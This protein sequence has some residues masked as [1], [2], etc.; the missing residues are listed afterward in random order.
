MLPLDDPRWQSYES[1]YRLL[2]DASVPLR[3]L[4]EHGASV[5]LWDE[6][7]QE[8]HHQGDLGSASYAAVP[9]LLKYAEHSPKLDWNVFGLIATIELTRPRNSPVPAELTEAYFSAIRSIPVVVGTHPDH[10]WDAVA[11]RSIVSCIA[12]ARDQRLLAQI[13]LELDEEATKHWLENELGYE[14]E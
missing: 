3:Q 7:W 14:L 12:L 1:G 4:L 5:E 10:A 13:S 8:L 11:T 9:Y 2:Y 6:L